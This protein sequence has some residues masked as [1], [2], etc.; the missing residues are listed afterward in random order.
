MI[1]DVK[2]FYLNTPMYEPKYMQ[3]PV[4]LIADEIKVGYKVSKFEHIGYIYVQINNG[5]YGLA[6]MGLLVNALLT[7][8][9]AKHRFKKTPHTPGLWR[10]HAKPIQFALVVDSLGIKY[11]KK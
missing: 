4:K 8:R 2:N 5:M 9:L 6:Q 10:H 1:E 11:E 3:I 7:N